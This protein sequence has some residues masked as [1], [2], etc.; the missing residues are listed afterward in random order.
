MLSYFGFPVISLKSMVILLWV[1]S[2][3]I[4]TETMYTLGNNSDLDRAF[5]AALAAQ[6]Y[7]DVVGTGDGEQV[8]ENKNQG[9]LNTI[10][11]HNKKIK[12]FDNKINF[13][14]NNFANAS[15]VREYVEKTKE[16]EQHIFGGPRPHRSWREFLLFSI[17]IVAIIFI[18][19][20]IGKKYLAPWLFKS[21]VGESNGIQNRVSTISGHVSR[22]GDNG[23]R[24]VDELKNHLELQYLEHDKQL[25]DISQKLNDMLVLISDL[26][27]ER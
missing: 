26:P 7:R 20:K 4:S 27:A 1:I 13:I 15:H 16:I 23:K 9:L 11:N 25:K 3:I 5:D 8:N 6:R 21:V 12:Y 14:V 22:S 17:V 19:M 24:T 18:L 2:F 10:V